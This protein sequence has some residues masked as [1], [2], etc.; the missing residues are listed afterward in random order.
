ML[1]REEPQWNI[2]I[3]E[4]RTEWSIDEPLV[5][6]APKHGPQGPSCSVHLF[7]NIFILLHTSHNCPLTQLLQNW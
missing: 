4:G 7:G 6:Q 3:D 1:P 2:G 5:S